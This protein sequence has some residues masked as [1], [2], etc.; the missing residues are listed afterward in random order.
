MFDPNTMEDPDHEDDAEEANGR[1]ESLTGRSV[2]T[3]MIPG[4]FK[5]GNAAG[6]Q[7]NIES[8]FAKA[9]VFCQRD[10]GTKQFQST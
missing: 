3:M 2:K 6:N 7:Y 8:C 10:S 5:R 1:Q 9:Q 4:L